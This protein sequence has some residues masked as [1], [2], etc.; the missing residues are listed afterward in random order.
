MS[1]DD[2]EGVQRAGL[3]QSLG[4]V[5]CGV[6]LTGLWDVTGLGKIPAPFPQY[7]TWNVSS[8]LPIPPW[9]GGE[10]L[11]R[12][13]GFPDPF[14]LHTYSSHLFQETPCLECRWRK[15]QSP[16]LAQGAHCKPDVFGHWSK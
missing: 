5:G 4:A 15:C 3:G 12:N 8:M 9:G 7:L 6:I 11:P 14:R 10:T 16:M 2:W 13:I 1:C